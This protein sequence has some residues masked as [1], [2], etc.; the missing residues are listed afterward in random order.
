MADNVTPLHRPGSAPGFDRGAQLRQR[1]VDDLIALG[2]VVSA[3]VDAAMRKVRRELFAPGVSLDEV[4]RVFHDVVTKRD[5][6]GRAIGSMSAALLQAHMLEQ[7]DITGGMSVLEI[8]SGGY[9]AALLAELVG[10]SGDVTSVDIDQEI[11]DLAGRLLETAGYPQV[12]VVCADA[13]EKPR[14]HEKYDRILVTAGAWDIPPAWVDQLADDGL[15]LVPLQVRGLSSVMAFEKTDE[16][17]VSRSVTAFEVAAMQGAGAHESTLVALR[18]GEVALRFDDEP[19]VADPGAWERLLQTARVEVRSGARIGRF[20]HADMAQ[21]WLAT[22]LPGEFCRV[23]VDRRRGIGLISP[24]NRDSTAMATIGDDAFA[25]VTTR[26]TAGR[27]V[28]FVV[29]AFGPDR[30]AHGL[31]EEIAEQLRIWARDH[32]DGP[33]PQFRVYPAGTPDDALHPGRAI[34]KKHSRIT[35]TWPQREPPRPAATGDDANR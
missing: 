31:A 7:A 26:G 15:L 1:M 6:T 27:E 34:D 3:P 28:E 10:G 8:G 30:D 29:H 5:R 21:M 23:V 33:D 2:F 9:N 4:Y 19:P 22:A 24:P 13:A 20:G 25:Y 17:L 18:D 32:R 12:S 11:A 16:C 35:V 14:E